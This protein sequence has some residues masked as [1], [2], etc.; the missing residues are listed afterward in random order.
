MLQLTSR[1]K[2]HLLRVR[3]ERGVD[4]SAGARLVPNEGRVRLTF[5]QTPKEGDRLTQSDPIRVFVAPEVAGTLDHATIDVRENA[6]KN[7]LVFRR[8]ARRTTA[9]AQA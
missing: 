3:R 6:G 1:A 7:V 2:D 4:E 5:V 8:R 9:P